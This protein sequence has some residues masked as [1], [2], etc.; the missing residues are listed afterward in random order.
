MD[1]IY[2]YRLIVTLRMRDLDRKKKKKSTILQG[3][4]AR[5]THFRVMKL[6]RAA[7]MGGY[8]RGQGASH[9]KTRGS[10]EKSSLYASAQR[11]TRG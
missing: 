2:T 3:K 10:Q 5:L 4:I 1:M 6:P 9:F 7:F 8:I 11:R